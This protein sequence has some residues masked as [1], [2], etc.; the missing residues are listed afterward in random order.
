MNKYL[1]YIL[2][3]LVIVLGA[4][5]IMNAVDAYISRN[6]EQAIR[7]M[8]ASIIELIKKVDDLP[9]HN[10]GSIGSTPTE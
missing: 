6:S 1:Q 5:E 9:R 2:V 3:I 8:D 7:D 4:A 10:R